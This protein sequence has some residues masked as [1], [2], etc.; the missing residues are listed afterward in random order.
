MMITNNYL[1]Q[2]NTLSKL[3]TIN[4]LVAPT[5]RDYYGWN[6]E[7]I[8]S[9]QTMEQSN[10]MYDFKLLLDNKNYSIAVAVLDNFDELNRYLESLD[11]KNTTEPRYHLIIAKGIT[12][13]YDTFHKKFKENVDFYSPETFQCLH[14]EKQH[15]LSVEFD[16]DVIEST[17]NELKNKDVLKEYLQHKNFQILDESIINFYELFYLGAFPKAQSFL[18]SGFVSIKSVD[19]ESVDIKGSSLS[20][21]AILD[22]FN[23]LIKNK[24]YLEAV[25]STGWATGFESMVKF[26]FQFNID[27]KDPMFENSQ[28]LTSVK[29]E[30]NEF[31]VTRNNHYISHRIQILL[32]L[33][34]YLQE[35]RNIYFDIFVSY[36]KKVK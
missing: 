10:D 21:Y 31:K 18:D 8:N 19:P 6:R 30:A 25:N 2:I 20:E 23:V 36:K 1:T 4:A 26:L 14:K 28:I 3:Q 24:P 22:Y 32:E 33:L 29:E 34:K 17:L 35:K 13:F 27:L 5:L 11:S 12:K 9:V 15:L 16:F 7:D